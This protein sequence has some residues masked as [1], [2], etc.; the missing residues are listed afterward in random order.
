MREKR[1]SRKR[2]RKEVEGKERMCSRKRKRRS[3]REERRIREG[4]DM[5]GRE[6]VG[7]G[8]RE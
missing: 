6:G 7:G 4:I 3:R 1:R 5:G 8:R 2:E